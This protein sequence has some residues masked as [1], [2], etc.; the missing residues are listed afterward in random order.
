M[1]KKVVILRHG[2]YNSSDWWLTES[3]EKYAINKWEEL[4]KVIWE[5]SQSQ[6]QILSSTA[7]RAVWTANWIKTWMW[8]EETQIQLLEEL[9]DDNSH[10]WNLDRV[11]DFINS[12]PP[13]LALII[14]THLDFAWPLAKELWYKGKIGYRDLSYLDSYQFET[15]MRETK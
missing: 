11:I 10:Y 6:I 13:H 3:W 7:P 8:A 1:N 4:R 12:L 15:T 9:W 5:V 14:I 2:H